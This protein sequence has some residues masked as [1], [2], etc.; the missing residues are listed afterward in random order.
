MGATKVSV[1]DTQLDELILKSDFPKLKVV[2]APRLDKAEHDT[3]KVPA[4]SA[5]LLKTAPIW[6]YLSVG[7][8]VIQI[9]LLLITVKLISNFYKST[10]EP[11][12]SDNRVP[13][14]SG[15]GALSILEQPFRGIVSDFDNGQIRTLSGDAIQVSDDRSV[16]LSIDSNT[17]FGKSGSSLKVRY[18]L[19]ETVNKTVSIRFDI[20]PVKI[21]QKQKI[22]L[23]MKL[24][25]PE[26]VSPDI[27]W[28]LVDDRGRIFKTPKSSAYVFWKKY[29]LP[30]SQ[31]AQDDV[32][33][34][35]VAL[36]ANLRGT[37]KVSDGIFFVDDLA[38]E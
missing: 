6:A 18:R 27:E 9:A 11:K 15:K 1:S 31:S 24:D 19:D 23:R 7:A 2:E 28:S 34:R 17:K 22:V 21:L 29:E 35:A 4:N 20:A 36:I 5:Q 38:I 32:T 16:Q 14:E 10:S 3:Q 13:A 37:Q 33:I 30:I 25:E 12:L 8:L 26:M